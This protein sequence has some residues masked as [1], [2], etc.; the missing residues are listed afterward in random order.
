MECLRALT[1][2]PPMEK[3]FWDFADTRIVSL[4]ARFSKRTQTLL[5][6][7]ILIGTI[8]IVASYAIYIY[9]N[10]YY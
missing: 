2:K 4:E 5:P 1:G 7:Y 3:T 9:I 8:L 6:L 10:I